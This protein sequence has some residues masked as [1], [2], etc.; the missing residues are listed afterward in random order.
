MNF[1]PADLHKHEWYDNSKL[2]MIDS[3]HR[4]GYWALVHTTLGVELPGLVKTPNDG[5]LFGTCIHAGLAAYYSRPTAPM[6]DRQLAMFNAFVR[7]HSKLFPTTR[8]DIDPKHTMESGLSLLDMYC[9]R[10]RD[11][12]ATLQPIETELAGVV[13]IRPRVGEDPFLPFYYVMRTDGLDRRIQ[14]GDLLVKEHKTTSWGVDKEIKKRQVD[15]QTRGYDFVLRSFPSSLPIVGVL[16]NVLGVSASETKEE[17][18]F[19]REI[20]FHKEEELEEWRRG[21]ILKVEG[22]RRMVAEAARYPSLHDKLRCFDQRTEQC[23]AFGLCAFYDA[24]AYGPGALDL[25]RY[26]PNEW[27][28]LTVRD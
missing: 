23:T 12:A 25:R 15:N 22:W 7:S 1:L 2:E 18:L 5:A 24:C 19:A 17:K 26:S 21:V 9:D 3:C 11:E 28:P 14:Q 20:Y 8:Q 16:V 27:N 13:V 4:R 10:Y 6:K